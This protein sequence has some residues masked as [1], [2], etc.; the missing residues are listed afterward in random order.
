ME[1]A[2]Y[3]PVWL[4]AA[5]RK[6][7]IFRLIRRGPAKGLLALTLHEAGTLATNYA[8]ASALWKYEAGTEPGPVDTVID[9]IDQ[10]ITTVYQRRDRVYRG[11][12]VTSFPLQP[13]AR[14]PKLADREMLMAK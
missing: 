4:A 7:E 10:H 14:T 3:L 11:A 9:D 8:S 1:K 6:S 12:T 2:L 5:D 13:S